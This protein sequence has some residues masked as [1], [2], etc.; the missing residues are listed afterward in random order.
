MEEMVKTSFTLKA[1][2]KLNKRIYEQF[3]KD[4]GSDP[5]LVRGNI[6]DRPSYG[7]RP[8]WTYKPFK[9]EVFLFSLHH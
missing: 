1:S 4:M 2:E 8:L 7:S 5:S 6:L 9:K 3:A